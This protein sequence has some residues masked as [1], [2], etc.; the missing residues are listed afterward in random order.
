[1]SSQTALLVTRLMQAVVDEGSGVSLRNQYKLTMD[2]AGKT[3]TTQDQTDGWF[4]GFTPNLVTGVWVGGENPLIRFRTLELGGGS[5]TAL[6]V[7]AEFMNG[8]SRKKNLG[9]TLNKRFAVLPAELEQKLACESYVDNSAGEGTFIDRIIDDI[10]NTGGRSEED[11]QR[12][13]E[14]KIAREKRKEEE[15]SGREQKREERKKR[16]EERKRKRQEKDN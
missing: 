9:I 7:W 3:G 5:A 4:I 13:E 10:F 16:R 15:K 11:K 8:L 12:E 14:E 2:I 1:M 6:P